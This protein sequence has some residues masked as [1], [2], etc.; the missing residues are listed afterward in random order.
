MIATE[1]L[2]KGVEQG[3]ITAEQ[4]QRLRALEGIREPLEPSTSETPLFRDIE[5]STVGACVSSPATKFIRM[6]MYA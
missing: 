6:M 4:A 2:T 1:I 5:A 3:I